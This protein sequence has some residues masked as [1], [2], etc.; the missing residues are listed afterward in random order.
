MRGPAT[1]Y[2]HEGDRMPSPETGSCPASAATRHAADA[3]LATSPPSAGQE[4]PPTVL[5]AV[6]RDAPAAQA[7][8][9]MEQGHQRGPR[10]RCLSWARPTS[11]AWSTRVRASP[12][13]SWSIRA[14]SRAVLPKPLRPVI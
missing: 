7:E 14:R 10:S 6:S 5:D 8:K 9:R 1:A 2:S 11:D 3:A 13:D 4:R 12:A